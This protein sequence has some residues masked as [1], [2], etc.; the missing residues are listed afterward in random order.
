MLSVHAAGYDIICWLQPRVSMATHNKHR[1]WRRTTPPHNPPTAT[2]LALINNLTWASLILITSVMCTVLVRACVGLPLPQDLSGP[3]WG[4]QYPAG[5][6]LILPALS[7]LYMCG[8]SFNTSQRPSAV[9]PC[10]PDLAANG[11]KLFYA[12]RRLKTRINAGCRVGLWQL[13]FIRFFAVDLHLNVIYSFN[14]R[15]RKKLTIC[16]TKFYLHVTL[17]FVDYLYGKSYYTGQSWI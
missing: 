6:L 14:L 8:P 15:C 11:R 3:S 9:I 12:A 7:G 2:Q 16:K 13:N 4:K 1:Y 17:I 10:N 5:L